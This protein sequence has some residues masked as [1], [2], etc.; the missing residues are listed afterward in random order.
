MGMGYS[1]CVL[2]NGKVDDYKCCH[3]GGNTL[4]QGLYNQLF[5]IQKIFIL[6]AFTGVVLYIVINKLSSQSSRTH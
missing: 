2:K 5:L 1:F 3:T 6:I 4:N